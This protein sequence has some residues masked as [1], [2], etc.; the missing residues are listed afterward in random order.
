METQ[1]RCEYVWGAFMLRVSL[2]LLLLVAGLDKFIGGLDGARAGI[3][4]MF[5]KSWLP[6]ALSTPFIIAIPYAEVILG[7]LIILGLFRFF[8]LALGSLYMLALA[9][10]VMAIGNWDIVFRNVVYTALFTAALFTTPWDLIKLD[11]LLFR[12]RQPPAQ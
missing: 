2:G 10:G 9:F 4:G 3:E 12:R 6:A 7:G 5:T 1:H 8:F 11:S